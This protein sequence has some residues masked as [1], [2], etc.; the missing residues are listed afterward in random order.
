MRTE[1]PLDEPQRLSSPEGLSNSGIVD[2]FTF[3]PFT[4]LV[5]VRYT[6]DWVR[7]LRSGRVLLVDPIFLAAVTADDQVI[8]RMFVEREATRL[9][10]EAGTAETKPGSRHGRSGIDDE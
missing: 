8:M 6:A 4:G 3:N 5:E 9:K 2:S 1:P 10:S 7:I